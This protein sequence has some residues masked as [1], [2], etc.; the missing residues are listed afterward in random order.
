MLNYLNKKQNGYS[1]FH[2]IFKSLALSIIVSHGLN[3]RFQNIVAINRYEINVYSRNHFF[4]KRG[5]NIAYSG[6]VSARMGFNGFSFRLRFS[7]LITVVMSWGNCRCLLD[8]W[9]IWGIVLAAPV[10][11]TTTMTFILCIQHGPW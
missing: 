2:Q 7:F 11:M 3:H 4:F 8:P 6:S 9:E 5:R 10:A 1:L